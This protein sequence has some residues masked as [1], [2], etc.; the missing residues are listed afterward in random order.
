MMIRV[1]FNLPYVRTPF[2]VCRFLS[3]C[4]NSAESTA[5]LRFASRADLISKLSLHQQGGRT[6][7]EPDADLKSASGRPGAASTRTGPAAPGTSMVVLGSANSPDEVMRTPRR[8]FAARGIGKGRRDSGARR[9]KP[10]MCCAQALTA[11]AIL[12]R[13]TRTLFLHAKR[14]YGPGRTTFL[15]YGPQAHLIL[16]NHGPDAHI[17]REGPCAVHCPRLSCAE[18]LERTNVCAP[19]AAA[20]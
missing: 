3:H 20:A 11:D 6:Q 9:R 7:E 5:F 14:V 8:W 13:P 4:L 10:R 19:A 17:R 2:S 1:R 18:R 12:T 16:S 15:E